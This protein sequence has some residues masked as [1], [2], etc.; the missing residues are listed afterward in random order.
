MCDTGNWLFS[1][2]M[3]LFFILAGFFFR[4]RPLRDVVLGGVRRL[5]VPY[6]VTA[7]AIVLIVYGVALGRGEPLDSYWLVAA[8][9]GNGSKSHSSAF[10]ADMPVIG[11]ICSCW[12]CSGAGGLLRLCARRSGA[13]G[14]VPFGYSGSRRRQSSWTCMS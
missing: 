6:A 7:L 10:L 14:H 12:R 2:H 9:Y 5:L 8:L 4:P 13:N 3:P 11:A 1:F